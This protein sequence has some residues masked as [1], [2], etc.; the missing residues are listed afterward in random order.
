MLG[1]RVVSGTARNAA[2]GLGGTCAPPI[3]VILTLGKYPAVLSLEPPQFEFLVNLSTANR[4]G[5]RIPPQIL[6]E[7]H[8]VFR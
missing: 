5:F 1:L 7:A 8:E 6:L 2:C 3:A 4:M